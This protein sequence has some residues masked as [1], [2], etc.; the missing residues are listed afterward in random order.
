MVHLGYRTVCSMTGQ[1]AHSTGQADLFVNMEE[2]RLGKGRLLS[3]IVLAGGLQMAVKW[4]V[5][6]RW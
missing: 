5:G 1:T 4:V 3:F 6:A 2:L